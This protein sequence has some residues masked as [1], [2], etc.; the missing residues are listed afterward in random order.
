MLPNRIKIGVASDHA[1]FNLKQQIIAL[2]QG[3]GYEVVDFGPHCADSCDYPD[4]AHQLGHAVETGLVDKGVSTCGSGEG[5]SIVLNKYP[6]VRAA[7]AWRP[8]IAQLARQ[9]NDAN[10]LTLP[11]RFVTEREA[12]DMVDLF[13]N[14]PFEGGRHKKR[15]DKIPPTL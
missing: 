10:V 8:E 7:L 3:K 12:L 6:H 15:V 9:H 5:V 4:Y 13:F 2:L 1:G 14:T 11:A